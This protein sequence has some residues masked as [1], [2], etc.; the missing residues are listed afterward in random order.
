MLF[1][2]TPV[3]TPK[4][5]GARP[6]VSSQGMIVNGLVYT[7]GAV[8]KSP[9]TGEFVKG[10]IEQRTHQ[11]VANLKAILEAAGSSLD[12]V[13][14]VNVYITDMD[15]F[16]R[17]NAVYKQYWGSVK[18]VRTCVGV[19]SL[20]GYT[21]VEIKCVAVVQTPLPSRV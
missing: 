10:P 7:S 20:P 16:D 5:A 21:D 13:I 15:D 14:E 4:A 12:D 8:G 6:G 18:P 19:K 11:C 9:D 17:V 1:T 3:M 2:R